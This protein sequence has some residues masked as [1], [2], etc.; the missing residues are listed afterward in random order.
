MTWLEF[1]TLVRDQL[2][3]DS[4]RYNV[5]Q[6]A[7]GV[8]YI[9][10]KIRIA[11]LEIQELIPFYQ[12][13]HTTVWGVDDVDEQGFA[14][15]GFI[16]ENCTM[17]SAEV[18][19][20]GT[21]CRKRPVGPYPYERFT[22]L[23]CGSPVSIGCEVML[24]VDRHIREFWLYPKLQESTTQTWELFMVW[25]GKKIDFADGDTVPFDEEMAAVISEYVKWKIELEVNR[26]V[27]MAREWEKAF[28]VGRSKLHATAS[29]KRSMKSIS[30]D[31]SQGHTCYA[32]CG[33]GGATQP[34]DGAIEFMAFGDFGDD[35]ANE[36]AV[37]TLVKG[38]AP[39]FLVFLGDI[40]YPDGTQALVED[41]LLKYYD[42]Y[43][44]ALSYP[45]WG[46][47]DLETDEGSGYGAAL[48]TVYPAILALNSGKFYYNFV[49]GAAAEVTVEFFML[50]SGYTDADPREA[51]GITA[52]SVQGLWLQAALAASTADWKIVC[53]HRP[54]W[55][56]DTVHYPGSADMRWPF[57]TW[58]ADLL[59][60]GHGHNY[61][62]LLVGS[63]PI[64]VSGLGGS[65]K[66][67]FN[68]V[69]ATGSQFRYYAKYGAL[70]VTAAADRLQCVFFDTDRNMIDN[71]TYTK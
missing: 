42:Q 26:D 68:A 1:K 64:I 27:Q 4:P 38:M 48:G 45:I 70:K 39:D 41:R 59:L 23:T 22:D 12:Q 63:L 31:P 29:A 6:V 25:D 58:G 20:T 43:V 24:A 65:T 44:P 7:T 56:S 40:L 5:G 49:M 30:T 66:R 35:S 36:L 28:L 54:P 61:E 2:P 71:V 51:D 21:P 53:L 16:P 46:N 47:H 37:S 9:D 11:A 15:H 14:S 19:T 33:S 3:I 55:C 50:N 52:A 60:A 57:K 69:A 18:R 34:G 13:G 32:T 67:A 8:S 10:R 17:V 62:R